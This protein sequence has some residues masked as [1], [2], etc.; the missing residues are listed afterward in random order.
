M[1]DSTDHSSNRRKTLK[2]L[3]VASGVTV[4]G[5]SIP[6]TWTK[7]VVESVAL[8]AHAQTT[9]GEQDGIFGTA[10]ITADNLQ[11]W[12]SSPLLDGI[13][14]KAYASHDDF[15][16]ASCGG[17]EGGTGMFQSPC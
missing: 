1:S 13:L 8:P 5:A 11:W 16:E 3:G 15:A 7:P 2:A 9:M 14:P 17:I 6:S 12:K 10:I 4:T